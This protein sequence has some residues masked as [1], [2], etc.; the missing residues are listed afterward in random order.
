MFFCFW[1][2]YPMRCV[3]VLVIPSIYQSGCWPRLTDLLLAMRFVKHNTEVVSEMW[4]S[5]LEVPRWGET[6]EPRP[7]STLWDHQTSSLASHETWPIPVCVCLC[8]CS[9]LSSKTFKM[10]FGVLCFVGDA[11]VQVAHLNLRAS[12]E[13]EKALNLPAPPKIPPQSSFLLFKSAFTNTLHCLFHSS[14]YCF[15]PNFRWL[16]NSQQ[17]PGI[18]GRGKIK[19]THA[20]YQHKF[21]PQQRCY[22]HTE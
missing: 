18:C 14:I 16:R 20:V 8:V 6:S 2:F 7:L 9:S 5:R 15:A 12:Q 10:F 21:N 3:F 1:L 13:L 11:V 4:R 17:V 19:D 22:V